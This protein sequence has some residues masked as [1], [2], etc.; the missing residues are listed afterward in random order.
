[1]MISGKDQ[2]PGDHVITMVL[3]YQVWL[4]PRLSCGTL[5]GKFLPTV[6]TR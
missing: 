2:A 6:V 5:S 1:M 3:K 4:V